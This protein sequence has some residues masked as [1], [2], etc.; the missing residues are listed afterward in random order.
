M[1]IKLLVSAFE[2][3][4]S[5]LTGLDR[6]SP[7]ASSIVRFP[8]DTLDD[9]AELSIAVIEQER[10]RQAAPTAGRVSLSKWLCHTTNKALVNLLLLA[11]D[12]EHVSLSGSSK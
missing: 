10:R 11:V 3:A 6:D 4:K 7:S 8:L 12:L 1:L 9:E 5:K 2:R